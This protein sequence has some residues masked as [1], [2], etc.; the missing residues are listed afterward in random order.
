MRT[1]LVLKV[2]QISRDFKYWYG[3]NFLPSLLKR[4]LN[5]LFLKVIQPHLTTL[6]L[7]PLKILSIDVPNLQ[8]FLFPNWQL[9]LNIPKQETQL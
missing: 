1:Y 7:E 6:H 9:Y 4:F 5:P 3:Y 8:L 2:Y